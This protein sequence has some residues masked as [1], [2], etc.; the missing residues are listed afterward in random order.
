MYAAPQA[1]GLSFFLQLCTPGPASVEI[2]RELW[3]GTG[4]EFPT[5][6]LVYW[7]TGTCSRRVT[8][9]QSFGDQKVG[10]SGAV[11]ALT[12]GKRPRTIRTQ[13]QNV[14][15]LTLPHETSP[16]LQTGIPVRLDETSREQHRNILQSDGNMIISYISGRWGC[17][18]HL[19]NCQTPVTR[20]ARFQPMFHRNG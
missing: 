20:E 3:D 10:P 1:G 15:A 18:F 14:V 2:S 12:M 13:P 11:I 17:V 5:C 4:R 9:R 8:S 6:L 19:L 16:F 7:L